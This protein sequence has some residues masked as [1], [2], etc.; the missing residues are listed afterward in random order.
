VRRLGIAEADKHADA[1]GQRLEEVQEEPTDN[2]C[3]VSRSGQRACE[4]QLS[5]L[6]A[7]LPVVAD[8]I[9]STKLTALSGY[10]LLGIMPWND[11]DE[12]SVQAAASAMFK[13]KT[14]TSVPLQ[15]RHIVAGSLLAVERASLSSARFDSTASLVHRTGI[16][17]LNQMYADQC[18]LCN[19]Q[20]L[21][22][23]AKDPSEVQLKDLVR[24]ARKSMRQH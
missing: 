19:V 5:D 4:V 7:V 12:E 14:E 10:S 3:W 13:G 24:L 16:A 17:M 6:D 1:L 21:K 9:L 8:A 23:S 18:L 15:A 2:V 22:G 20:T 11:S